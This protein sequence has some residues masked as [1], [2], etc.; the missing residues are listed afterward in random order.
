MA[1]PKIL[2]VDDEPAMLDLL[3][4]R[5][6]ALG[7]EYAKA[8]DGVEAMARL[9]S[10]EFPIVITDLMMPNMDGMQLL[11]HIREQYPNTEVIVVTGYYDSLSYTEVIN[12]GASDYITKPFMSDELE[13]KLKRVQREQEL[14]RGLKSLLESLERQLQE[15]EESLDATSKSLTETMDRLKQLQAQ[16]IVSKYGRPW[17]H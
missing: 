2:I 9:R 12:A 4:L 13:A 11:K 10:D 14:I 7:Y 5:L 8:S 16:T 1:N 15:R 17:G 6:T 3:G